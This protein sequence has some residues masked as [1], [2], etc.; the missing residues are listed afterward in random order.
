MGLSP[1]SDLSIF[2]QPMGEADSPALL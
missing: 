2:E 1:K